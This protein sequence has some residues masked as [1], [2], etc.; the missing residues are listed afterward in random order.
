[1]EKRKRGQLSKSEINQLFMTTKS[2]SKKSFFVLLSLS[3]LKMEIDNTDSIEIEGFGLVKL[4]KRKYKYAF[5]FLPNDDWQKLIADRGMEFDK[6]SRALM[7]T[8]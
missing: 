4:R 2:K 3:L 5:E 6:M 1:M 7:E 8:L